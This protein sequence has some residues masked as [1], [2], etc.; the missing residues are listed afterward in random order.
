MSIR[1]GTSLPKERMGFPS[2]VAS[3]RTTLGA[4]FAERCMHRSSS[5]NVRSN[6]QQMKAQLAPSSDL[7]SPGSVQKQHDMHAQ[8]NCTA[9]WHFCSPLSSSSVRSESTSSSSARRHSSRQSY[10]LVLGLKLAIDGRLSARLACA[11]AM[12]RFGEK[13]HEFADDRDRV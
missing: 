1:V 6:E 9:Q 10:S 13:T 8:H 5:P 7:I 3:L 11:C 2:A 12:A 4:L